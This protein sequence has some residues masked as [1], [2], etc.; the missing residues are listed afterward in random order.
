MLGMTK[1]GGPRAVCRCER[2]LS[3]A[4][5]AGDDGVRWV[6]AAYLGQPAPL[7]RAGGG[8]SHVAAHEFRIQVAAPVRSQ[9]R[10]GSSARLTAATASPMSN[11][12][13]RNGKSLLAALGRPA[14]I[15]GHPTFRHGESRDPP[16]GRRSRP[17][18]VSIA[19]STSEMFFAAQSFPP[20]R[21]DPSSCLSVS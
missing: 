10:W 13:I 4:R 14:I 9:C 8:G 20:V 12:L 7:V 15:S 21:S 11:L 2:S 6:G 19:L 5:Y 17:G 16:S 3:C 18:L 1:A